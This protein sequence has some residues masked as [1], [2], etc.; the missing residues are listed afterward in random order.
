ML[1]L[2]HKAVNHPSN[3]SPDPYS[4]ETHPGVSHPYIPSTYSTPTCNPLSTHLPSTHYPF[5]PLPHTPPCHQ[6][7]YIR[8]V[9]KGFANVGCGTNVSS[10]STSNNAL[11][12]SGSSIGVDYPEVITLVL[13]LGCVLRYPA[14]Y[15]Y[16]RAVLKKMCPALFCVSSHSMGTL[17]LSLCP[18]TFNSN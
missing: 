3:T 1:P 9:R 8:A 5:K 11:I 13:L 6:R 2:I 7:T 18:I 15:V 16:A 14:A 4:T 12:C 17:C 10:T